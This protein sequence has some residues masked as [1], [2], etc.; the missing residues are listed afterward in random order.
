MTY[1]Y[2]LNLV[3]L[4]ELPFT[5]IEYN[6][7]R[8]IKVAYTSGSTK[9]SYSES[10]DYLNIHFHKEEDSY[11]FS[12]LE[13]FNK[14]MFVTVFQYIRWVYWNFRESKDRG[15]FI[16]DYS[17][18]KGYEITYS[19][20]NTKETNYIKVNNKEDQLKYVENFNSTKISINGIK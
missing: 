3:Q 8:Q 16:N 20:G 7:G 5:G 19:N 14:N 1:E 11:I 2:I 13:Y 18:K 4:S 15:Y 17:T 10:G 9:Q 12:T 6:G